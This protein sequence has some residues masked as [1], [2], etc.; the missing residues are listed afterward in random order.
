MLL[1]GDYKCIPDFVD[2]LVIYNLSGFVIGYEKLLLF[3]CDIITNQP[4]FWDEKS[5]DIAYGEMLLKDNILFVQMMKIIFNLYNGMNVFLIVNRSE[6]LDTLT[7]SLLK[8]IQQRYG[9][10]YQLLESVDDI[11]I[12]DDSSFSIQGLY[13]LDTTDKDRYLSLTGVTFKGEDIV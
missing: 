12:Y 8:F 6:V 4:M 3:P 1:V 2:D 9:Y 5:S 10:N 7:E 11:N 13:N